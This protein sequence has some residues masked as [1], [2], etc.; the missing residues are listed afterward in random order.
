MIEKNS[1]PMSSR[2]EF[3][4]KTIKTTGYVLP[5]VTAFK[6]GSLNAWA[7]S[8]GKSIER[9]SGSHHVGF[10]ERLVRGIESLFHRD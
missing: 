10:F 2:R 3:L 4:K 7:E 1:S 6:L 9:R 5:L 8:Y